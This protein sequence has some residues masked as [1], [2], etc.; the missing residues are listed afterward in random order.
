[1][2]TSAQAFLKAA[3]AGKLDELEAH[4][5]A[6]P[7]LLAAARSTSKGCTLSPPPRKWFSSLCMTLVLSNRFLLS[8]HRLCHA[9]RRYGWSCASD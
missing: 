4:L 6:D 5:D 9:L 2:V 8:L 1:M 3:Q 7:S